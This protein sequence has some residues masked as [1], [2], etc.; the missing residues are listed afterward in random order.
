MIELDLELPLSRFVLS[1]S[2][3][4][5]D[6]ATGVM[7]PSGA[8]KTSLLEAI[9]GLR[10]RALGRVSVDGETLLDS[11]RGL[12]LTPERRQ[13]GYVPQDAGLFPHLT[14]GDNVR[15]APRYDPLR[16]K[17]AVELLEIGEL[18]GRYPAALS[19]GERQRVALARA[20]ARSPRLLLLDEPLGGLDA[21]LRE[22]IVPYLLRLRDEWRT[23]MLYVTHSVG[24]VLA[25]TGD[26]LLLR[27]G[28]LEAQGPPRE[29]LESQGALGQGQTLDNLLPGRILAHDA[30][31]G[32]TRF[33]ADAGLPLLL[34][35]AEAR[36]PGERATA[37]FRAEDV[38]VS[39][40]RYESLSARNLFEAELASLS[41]LGADATLRCVL[42]GGGATLWARLTPGAVQSLDLRAGRRVWL[43]LKS[44]SIRLL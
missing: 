11:S 44:H 14:A 1:L 29:L 12:R 9:V 32:V 35:L 41:R 26:V 16:L 19:G 2:V 37:A 27:D 30:V 23:P 24:E 4:L 5:C 17:Q 31:A 28:K 43:A 3:R 25:L 21:P 18:L 6:P 38:L 7:G 22:R 34:P 40:A 36:E 20:L 33:A 10:P 15:F 39:T 13:I 8:G 42:S